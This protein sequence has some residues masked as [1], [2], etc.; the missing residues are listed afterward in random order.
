MSCTSCCKLDA[1][2]L[3][4]RLFRR[5]AP[6]TSRRAG[7]TS[8]R[9]ACAPQ[10]LVNRLPRDRGEGEKGTPDGADD[11]RSRILSQLWFPTRNRTGEAGFLIEEAPN[12]NFLGADFQILEIPGHCPGSPGSLCSNPFLS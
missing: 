5:G 6:S 2:V 11:F 10:T 7:C 1:H 3:I 9:G 4:G 12:R 8:T